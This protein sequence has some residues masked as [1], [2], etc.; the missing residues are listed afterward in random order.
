MSEELIHASASRLAALM[1]ARAVSPV[2][3]VEAHLRR[4]ERVNPRLNALVSLA[5]DAVERAREAEALIMKGTPGKLLLGVPVTVK[6][7]IAVA[8]LPA[9]SGSK[10]RAG[11]VP[12]A[13]APAVAFLR[14]AGAIVVGKTNTSELALDYTTENAVY[15][16][17]N[18]PHDPARTPGGS[19]GGC[20]AAVAACLTAA[21]VGSDLAGS[22]RV[23][24]HF[25]GVAGLRPTSGRVSGVGH[26]PSMPAPYDRGASLGPLA[27]TVE[28][29]ELLFTVLTGD[30]FELGVEELEARRSAS[31]ARLEGLRVAWCAEDGQVPVTPETFEAV[32]SAAGA[33]RSAGL[34][35][36]E[37]RPPGVERAT[38]LWLSLFSRATQ[39]MVA[40]VYEGREEDAG[41]T[42]RALLRRASESKALGQ[43]E[44]RRAW[45]ERDRLRA[46]LLRWME[47]TPIL[48]AP[49]GA[50][51]AF[52]H[53]EARRV[54]VC[55]R[56]VSTFH[57]FGYAQAFNVFDLP[58]VCVPARR[59]RE[60]L[61]V[62]VQIVGR[63]DEEE[64]VLAAARIVEEALGGWQPPPEITP[65]ASTQS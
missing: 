31:R 42:A 38:E 46:E 45:A 30:A 56:S 28:D 11:Y 32:K 12:A 9:A 13:D 29:L 26:F 52:R 41:A 7:T 17:A 62:G 53:E 51:P 4:V 20:A 19:S 33:L 60:G 59:T 3:V 23:P 5:S 50:V 1:R 14:E 36:E 43:E 21:S 35:V 57:A 25:C 16:R 2:E 37:S 27:R 48:V 64:S 65:A 10:L 8:G 54:E 18:N 47:S 15:P 40:S 24:A 55:G 22:I 49:V 58:A 63:P 34:F 44:E 6:D 39:E 61:P